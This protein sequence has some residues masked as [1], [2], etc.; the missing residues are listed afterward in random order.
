MI[1][2]INGI[3]VLH[4]G[5]HFN[6][7]KRDSAIISLEVPCSYRE[8]NLIEVPLSHQLLNLPLGLIYSWVFNL[9]S[10]CWSRAGCGIANL[11]CGPLRTL[12]SKKISGITKYHMI[13]VHPI[14][15]GC[16]PTGLEV[17]ISV[18]ATA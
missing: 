13:P 3:I 2:K 15:D 11:S 7:S 8:V 10:N 17:S 6:L 18:L 4:F 12:C 9:I 14:E 5:Q 1:P 16:R